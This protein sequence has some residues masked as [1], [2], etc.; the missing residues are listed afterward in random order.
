MSAVAFAKSSGATAE[1]TPA[2][3]EQVELYKTRREIIIEHFKRQRLRI[4][5]ARVDAVAKFPH[6]IQYVTSVIDQKADEADKKAVVDKSNALQA[7]SIDF[8]QGRTLNSEDIVAQYAQ[9]T[10]FEGFSNREILAEVT[11]SCVGEPDNKYSAGVAGGITAESKSTDQGQV[12]P[13]TPDYCRCVEPQ[14][15]CVSCGKDF[16]FSDTIYDQE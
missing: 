2:A 10:Y 13:A 11:A 7:L 6:L 15:G 1:A 12:L 4:E 3:L 8:D 5:Q 14:W 16:D 9:Q